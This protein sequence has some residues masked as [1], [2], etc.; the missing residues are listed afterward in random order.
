M[1]DSS[2]RVLLASYTEAHTSA[3]IPFLFKRAGCVAVDVYAPQGSW[4]LK[5]R[6]R[7][8][9]HPADTT[10][11]APYIRKLVE[12]VHT[13]HYDWVVFIDD[14]ALY[15]AHDC[16][17]DTDA[18]KLLPITTIAHKGLVAS[19][20]ALSRMCQAYG[21]RTPAFAIYDGTSDIRLAAAGISF[22]LLLKID[23]SAGGL[24]I[25]YCAHT[26]ELAHALDTIPHEQRRGLLIQEYIQGE[27]ISAETL[28]RRGALVAYTRGHVIQTTGDEFSI[29]RTR[30][31]TADT[32]FEKELR[33]IGKAFGLDG[34][35][36]MTFLHDATG[37]Y[38]LV[39]A[40]MRPH[41][42]FALARLCGVDFS[43]AIRRYLAGT[44]GTLYQPAGTSVVVRH[45][46]RD[47][48]WSIKHRD[49]RNLAA[50]ASNRD[51]R[52]KSIPFNDP[53]LLWALANNFLLKSFGR[54]K[55]EALLHIRP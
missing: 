10:G 8:A 23:R 11:P 27:N 15:A 36:S 28:Y 41:A 2:Q 25:S 30:E 39:E 5:N 33:R 38:Y 52:W 3:E 32:L 13:A 22:P 14:A 18:A 24:G 46:A 45:F 17:D 37:D 19:K 43:D 21:V 54:R 50:W 9:W 44:P 20:A 31:Y 16:L 55:T 48:T 26:E 1:A 42:W 6:Y 40:D 34:F 47:V 53:R 7:D 49:I 12:L 51:G 4:L 29:S 35:C